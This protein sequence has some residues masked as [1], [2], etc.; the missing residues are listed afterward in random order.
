MNR[1]SGVI[2]CLAY[3]IGLL[4]TGIADFSDT[5]PSH[6]EWIGRIF[7]FSLLTL[8]TT[9]F[10][11]RIWWLS[12]PRKIWLI[13][14]LVSILAAIYFEFRIP[15]PA[16]N[17][18]SQI[19]T[20]NISSQRVTVTGNSLS[21]SRLNRKGNLQF[22]LQVQ[23]VSLNDLPPEMAVGKLYVTLPNVTENRL[24][25][26]QIVTLKGLLYRPRP[27]NNPG[28]FDFQSYLARQ[29][30]FAGLKGTEIIT[31]QHPPMGVWQLRERIVKAQ[32]QG[33]GTAKGALLSSITIGRQAVD[34]PT[35][36][37]DLF[38]KTGLAH[39]LAASGF[40][41]ALLL[42]VVLSITKKLS[43]RQQFLVGLLVLLGYLTLTGLQPSVMRAV[44]MGI[45]ALTGM[46]S[47]RKVN[48]L[49]SL[50]LA[51]TILLLFQPLWIWDLGFQL[52]FLATFGLIVTLP[53]LQK[54]LDYLPSS[55]AEPI[56]IT[57]AATLWT[58][59][60]LMYNFSSIALYSLWANV[61][62]TPLVMLI[63]L[64]GMFSA[65]VSLLYP[66]LGSAIAG[67]LFYPI[68]FLLQI[69]AIFP[70]LPASTYSTGKLS[71]GV[72]IIIYGLLGLCC[73]YH[74][75]QRRWPLLGLFI[76]ALVLIPIIY[77]SLTVTQVTILAT[78]SD[79]VIIIQNRGQTLLVNGNDPDT[80]NYTILPFLR[81]Q[82][83]NRIQGAIAL[84]SDQWSVIEE[85]LPIDTKI[86]L[87]ASPKVLFGAIELQ[88]LDP[89]NKVVQLK[90][91]ETIWLWLNHPGEAVRLPDPI[92]PLALIWKGKHLASQWLEIV[93]PRVAIAI[94]PSLSRSTRK[95]LKNARIEHYW[96]GRE[97]AI[98][99]TPQRGFQPFLEDER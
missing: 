42:G 72:M 83:I 86:A 91:N 87:T 46:V 21:E 76:S 23:Q 36:I 54:K 4:S 69:L 24:Y 22:W 65:F 49:G 18:I 1:Y 26:G 40:H 60:L 96:T 32:I 2:I 39:V 8:L 11:P 19:V 63:S 88:S 38:I 28:A 7:G 62:T 16:A 94:A 43:P 13:A 80:I 73:R 53:A 58:L 15:Y 71:L 84:Q 33:L 79:P 47:N 74:V 37:Q 77:H 14:G 75:W 64:G 67:I 61:I 92:P 90:V 98:Q 3:S 6:W 29:G 35:D 85:N 99:W 81:Q 51:G 70:H 57:L 30:T 12:P 10:V 27:A 20:G 17:D 59:P 68:E 25:S 56:G 82:G 55:L 31:K 93:K 5:F 50:I 44:L 78:K 52:S 89:D 48:S 95:Y 97:G 45:A 66:P 9:I 34:L 41:V